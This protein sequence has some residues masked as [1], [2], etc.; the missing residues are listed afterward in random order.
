MRNQIVISNQ[1]A[2][3]IKAAFPTQLRAD[4]PGHESLELMHYNTYGSDLSKGNAFPD[5]TLLVQESVE[6]DW[7]QPYFFMSVN[8]RL[9]RL[10]FHPIPDPMEV[11]ENAANYFWVYKAEVLRLTA[12][13]TTTGFRN[14]GAAAGCGVGGTPSSYPYLRE[15]AKADM[16][17]AW[18]AEPNY[19]MFLSHAWCK[20]NFRKLDVC[21][22][23]VGFVFNRKKGRNWVQ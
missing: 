22:M 3:M 23:V 2:A 12:Q 11:H 18:K 8:H 19:D 13:D 5:Y 7:S 15:P 1:N 4:I 17:A 20:A 6:L 16:Q 10:R 9:K 21:K 14:Y